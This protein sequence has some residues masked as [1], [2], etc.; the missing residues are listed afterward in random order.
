MFRNKQKLSQPPVD[1]TRKQLQPSTESSI[2][3]DIKETRPPEIEFSQKSTKD[4]LA[5]VR[6][7]G[8]SRQRMNKE[9]LA[10]QQ[11]GRSGRESSDVRAPIREQVKREM[12]EMSLPKAGRETSDVSGR[13]SRDKLN[14][15]RG[16]RE[17]EFTT[18]GGR[19][20]IEVSIRNLDEPTDIRGRGSFD[21]P[22]VA[23]GISR[24]IE[25]LAKSTREK[26]G[27]MRSVR[28]NLETQQIKGNR[29]MMEMPV[30]NSRD[31]ND[32]AR[33]SRDIN[34]VYNRGY[35]ESRDA[36]GKNSRDISNV[37]FRGNRDEMYMKM[38]DAGGDVRGRGDANELQS[39]NNRDIA[40]SRSVRNRE[41]LHSRNKRE[42]LALQ[43]RSGHDV[44]DFAGRGGNRDGG[45]NAMRASRYDNDRTDRDDILVNRGRD[46]SDVALR[47]VRDMSEFSMSRS[48]R[49]VSSRDDMS[50]RNREGGFE[51]SKRSE[52]S[53]SRGVPAPVPP[54]TPL[55]QQPLVPITQMKPLSVGS[56][57]GYQST[58]GP[59]SIAAVSSTKDPMKM[60]GQKSGIKLTLKVNYLF[61]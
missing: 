21:M 6:D 54:P 11:P 12:T 5:P 28:D 57:H 41:E 1:N 38:R 44:E 32:P 31:G 14:N 2:K 23:R 51:M 33:G 43:S 55:S 36:T 9:H 50:G 42:N 48:G 22:M 30:R 35:K 47:P 10:G 27:G 3:T 34:D 46:D 26:E 58:S 59:A 53:R 52:S 60:S 15:A 18:R 39:R 24:D 29:E 40:D 19:E 45:Q 37:S 4:T 61:I 13:A 20:T 8:D 16:D 7:N 25:I 56:S 17:T 49:D